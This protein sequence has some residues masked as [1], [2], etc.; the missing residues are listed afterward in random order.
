MTGPDGETVDFGE[1]LAEDA[2][3]AA[4]GGH[5]VHRSG[6]METPARVADSEMDDAEGAVRP[7]ILRLTEE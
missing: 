7:R 4:A 1:R 2:A 6:Y 5:T 3:V